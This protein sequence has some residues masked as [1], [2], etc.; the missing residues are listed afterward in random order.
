MALRYQVHARREGK[1]SAGNC[2]TRLMGRWLKHY[3]PDAHGGLGLVEWTRDVSQALKFADIEE[4]A[5]YYRQQSTIR[6]LRPD[7]QPNRPLTGYT[8][9]LEGRYDIHCLSLMRAS[10]HPLGPNASGSESG[11]LRREGP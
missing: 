10:S 4:A 1:R 6:P 8:V 2:S 11:S 3:D 5:Q 9:T 7:G